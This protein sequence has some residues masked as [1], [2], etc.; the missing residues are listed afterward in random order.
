MGTYAA[1]LGAWTWVIRDPNAAVTRSAT[2][3]GDGLWGCCT[4]H[5]ALSGEALLA[6]MVTV[7]A[8]AAAEHDLKCV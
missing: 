8:A 3:P 5:C 4:W 1:A 7:G 2:R 6:V